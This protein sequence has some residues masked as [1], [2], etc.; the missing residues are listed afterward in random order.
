M[1]AEPT[2]QQFLRGEVEP[3]AFPH[4]EH[5]RM[6][7]EMLRQHDFTEALLHFSRTLR[8]AVYPLLIAS[9]AIPIVLMVTAPKARAAS[10]QCTPSGSICSAQE[11]PCC[12]G[13]TCSG[14]ICL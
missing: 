2:L 4:R 6:G 9:Q 3:A 8:Q 14:G 10:S 5:V 11:P 7:F 12:P 1:S 13:S